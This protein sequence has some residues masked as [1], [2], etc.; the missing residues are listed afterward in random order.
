[1]TKKWESPPWGGSDSPSRVKADWNCLLQMLAF[2]LESVLRIPFFLSD[3]ISFEYQGQMLKW[4][5]LRVSPI[6]YTLFDQCD[7]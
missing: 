4:M 3:V 1:M 5:D 2:S 6:F 7:I